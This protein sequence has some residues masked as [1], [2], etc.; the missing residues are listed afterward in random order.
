M[1]RANRRHCEQLL[2]ALGETR[3]AV[4]DVGAL[5][6]GYRRADAVGR[7]HLVAEPLLF[8][9]AQRETPPDAV[10]G[11]DAGVAL[12]K[13]LAALRGIA[14][15]AAQR[16]GQGALG[17]AAPSGRTALGGAWRAAEAAFAALR[18]AM[19]EAWPDARSDHPDGDSP[20]A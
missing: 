16:V 14:W 1:A 15:R 4:R 20:P 10:L 12:G 13:D 19:Q 9:R 8:L 5:S 3:L 18:E 2:A 7:D 11:G 6:A 17:I